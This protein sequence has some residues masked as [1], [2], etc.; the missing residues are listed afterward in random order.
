MPR[1]NFSHHL[2]SMCLSSHLWETQNPLP[3][4]FVDCFPGMPRLGFCWFY[5]RTGVWDRP[6][7]LGD[8]RAGIL[9]R[10]GGGSVQKVSIL[11]SRHRIVLQMP[12]R[13][14]AGKE[15]SV[16]VELFRRR[17]IP[18]C[19]RR[20]LL[21]LWS[22]FYGVSSPSTPFWSSPGTSQPS[23][24]LLLLP[25][26]LLPLPLSLPRL[27]LRRL[28]PRLRP[29]RSARRLRRQSD[30]DR[31]L[32]QNDEDRLF[33]LHTT[34]GTKADQG[35]LHRRASMKWTRGRRSGYSSLGFPQY[36]RS[37][38]WGSWSTRDDS[39]WE[40]RIGSRHVPEN[41]PSKPENWIQ[42]GLESWILDWC[43]D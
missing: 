32:H 17:V 29:P 2:P 21:S 28:S 16:G 36:C 11:A 33:R 38:W 5:R 34:G 23:R 9:L 41:T 24:D 19:R 18:W 15:L 37:W 31:L 43:T 22:P 12:E 6:E 40:W 35:H 20:P 1:V 4:A 8:P 25:R 26:L 7:I 30:V 10:S 27:L 3:A 42:L 14:V 39:S 13:L